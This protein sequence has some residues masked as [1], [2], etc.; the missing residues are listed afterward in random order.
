[1]K[2]EEREARNEKIVRLHVEEDWRFAELARRFDLSHEAIRLI[3]RAAGVPEEVSRAIQE[4]RKKPVCDHCGKVRPSGRRSCSERCR[5]R[6]KSE[7]D[8]RVAVDMLNELRALALLL[9]HTPNN[10]EINRY[11]AYYHP[12]YVRLFGSIRTAQWL[13]GLTPNKTG[14]GRSGPTPLPEGFEAAWGWL[15]DELGG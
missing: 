1:M 4:R 15:V 14:G 8:S 11:G 5:K 12:R 6:L 3:V 10:H 7:R 2:A 13:A 9:G